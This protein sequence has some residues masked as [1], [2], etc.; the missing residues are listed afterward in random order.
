MEKSEKS[1]KSKV[2][3]KSIKKWQNL[4]SSCRKLN[5]FAQKT[6]QNG[7]KTQQIFQKLK[8]PEE[9]TTYNFLTCVQKKSLIYP[10]NMPC[11]LFLLRIV[12]IFFQIGRFSF[13]PLQLNSWRGVDFSYCS[14]ENENFEKDLL[15]NSST[16]APCANYVIVQASK[17]VTWKMF[18]LLSLILPTM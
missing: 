1:L 6:Q 13:C 16:C 7:Q 5:K 12:V 14:G 4:K 18:F 17:C 9:S 3:V 8:V 10:L 11:T 15:C 2:L